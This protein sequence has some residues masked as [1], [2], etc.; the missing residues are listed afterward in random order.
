M[1]GVYKS[2]Y[3]AGLVCSILLIR[4][5]LSFVGRIS[6]FYMIF[7]TYYTIGLFSGL[8]LLTI[9]VLQGF[10]NG[11]C[12]LITSTSTTRSLGALTLRSRGVAQLYA[13]AGHMKGLTIGDE[14]GGVYSRDHLYGNCQGFT[15]RVIASTFGGEIQAGVCVGVGITYEATIYAYIASTTCVGGLLVLS[16]YQGHCVGDLILTLFTQATTLFAEV[17][18]GLASTIANVANALDLS[19]AREY[20]LISYCPTQATT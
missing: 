9:G 3:P 16:A 5:L 14:G 1:W 19:G 7:I 10:G 20:S 2:G 11:S 4:R 8:F 18:G 15:P 17:I 12:V 13:L 6:T